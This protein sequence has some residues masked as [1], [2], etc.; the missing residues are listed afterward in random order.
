LT[1]LQ[2]GEEGGYLAKEFRVGGKFHPESK[3]QPEKIQKDQQFD[4]TSN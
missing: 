4:E 2:Q 3:Y 1:S